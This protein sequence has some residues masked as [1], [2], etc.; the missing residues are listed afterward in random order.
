LQP[1]PATM[2]QSSLLV[3]AVPSPPR[4]VH[5]PW[6]QSSGTRQ[7]LSASHGAS[8]GRGAA[9]TF[10]SLQ[11]NSSWQDTDEAQGSPA[12][13]RGT[14]AKQGAPVSWAQRRDWH[15]NELAHWALL[16]SAPGLRQGTGSALR[17]RS[18]QGC[19][20]NA[21][22]QAW[23]GQVTP[24]SARRSHSSWTR[25]SQSLWLPKARAAWG[26]EQAT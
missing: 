4:A 25:S 21:S 14:Q 24:G 12:P 20:G 16:A 23:V 11:T 8:S 26:A 22:A 1:I 3:Q 5:L 9:H 19:A 10:R 15:W 6:R 2:S 13:P 7:G 17:S 18:A